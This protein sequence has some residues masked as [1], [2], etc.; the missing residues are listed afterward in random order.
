MYFKLYLNF[1]QG[2]RRPEEG[3]RTVQSDLLSGRSDENGGA[4]EEGSGRSRRRSA[5]ERGTAAEEGRRGRP[6]NRARASG[7][8]WRKTRLI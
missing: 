4:A 2:L 3:P 8:G 1:F 6:Q 5:E 7:R